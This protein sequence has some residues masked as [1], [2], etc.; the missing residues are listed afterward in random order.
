MNKNFHAMT[1]DICASIM[2]TVPAEAQTLKVQNMVAL[3]VSGNVAQGVSD[4]SC[5]GWFEGF[6]AALRVVGRAPAGSDRAVCI[7]QGTTVDQQVLSLL[8]YVEKNQSALVEDLATG[9]YKAL[10]S[11]YPCPR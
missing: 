2:P 7:P 10:A 5:I 11:S 9:T 6:S 4:P 1:V 8:Q 3:C